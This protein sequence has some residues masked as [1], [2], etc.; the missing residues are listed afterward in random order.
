MTKQDE[1]HYRRMAR[2]Y[3]EAVLARQIKKEDEDAEWATR[4]GRQEEAAI[5][6]WIGDQFRAVQAER[7]E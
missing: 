4:N 7:F 5:H 6:A 3:S 1:A 2:N